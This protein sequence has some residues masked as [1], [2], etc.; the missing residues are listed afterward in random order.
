MYN[1]I[2]ASHVQLHQGIACTCITPTSRNSQASVMKREGRTTSL[3]SHLAVSLTTPK[4]YNGCALCLYV[5]TPLPLHTFHLIHIWRAMHLL[6]MMLG[7]NVGTVR[8][9]SRQSAPPPPPPPL[10]PPPPPPPP[11]PPLC[12]KLGTQLSWHSAF[13]ILNYLLCA[14][15]LSKVPVI[16][17][18]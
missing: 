14:Y 12:L 16:R 15:C 3:H 18:Q 10:L 5:Y 1:S 13:V 2:R 8:N 7:Q 9:L 4:L 11:P 6:V 17:S